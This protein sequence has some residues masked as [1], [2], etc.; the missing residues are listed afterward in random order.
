[1]KIQLFKGE[2]FRRGFL[3]FLAILATSIIAFFANLIISKILGPESFGTF[4]T[5]LY[6][7][8]FLPLIADLGINASLTKYI[9]EF[10][11]ENEKIKHLINWFLKIKFLSHIFIIAVIFLLKDS[12]ALYFLKDASLS[13]LVIA[14]IFLI[15][16][17]F[18]STFSS[19][20][21]GFQNFKLYSLSQFLNSTISFLISILLSPLGVFYMIIGYSLGPLIGNIPNILFLLKKRAFSGYEK[22]DMKKIFFK[23]SLPVYPIELSVNFFSVIVP[24]LSLFFSQKLI[25]YYSFA[26]MFYYIT[27][28]IPSSLSAVLFPKISELN[29]LKRHGDAKIILRKTF[30][31]YSLVVIAGFAFVFLFSE[32]FISLISQEFLPSLLMFKV[33]VFLGF[34]FGYNV[35]YSNYL[36][37][38]GK[39]KKFALFTLAQN[40][41]LI[42]ASFLLLS[43]F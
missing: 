35:I 16:F 18:F 11:K 14:G 23:F 31:Y 6:L 38:L 9:A 24:L 3:V 41:L 10:G 5:V 33:I 17:T 4:K 20:I 28:I 30:L 25:G 34:I 29:G 37:G 15:G 42:V 40:I 36:K 19:I 13:Y 22:I 2:L 27:T 1:M 32:W 12:I 21:L 8:A 26:F 39:V 7:F 43:N